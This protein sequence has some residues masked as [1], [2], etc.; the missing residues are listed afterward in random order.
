M[1][2]GL[3]AYVNNPEKDS[4]LIWKK[5]Y[6]FCLVPVSLFFSL[7]SLAWLYDLLGSSL[8]VPMSACWDT[9]PDS[10]GCMDTIC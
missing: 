6:N 8:S 2:K 4:F 9:I 5:G 1:I 3:P 7:F 10:E